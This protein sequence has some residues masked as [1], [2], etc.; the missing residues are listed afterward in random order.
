MGPDE[1][2]RKAGRLERRDEMTPGRFG[3]ARRR[4]RPSADNPVQQLSAPARSGSWRP[5]EGQLAGLQGD[6]SRKTAGGPVRVI[7]IETSSGVQV[8]RGNTQVS[9]YRV[10]LPRVS[11]ES[12]GSLAETL[13]SPD[14]PWAGDLF[15]HDAR[16]SLACGAGA[17]SSPGGIVEGPQ[18]DTL[19][20]VRNSS[21]IQLGNYNLQHNEFRVKACDVAVRADRAGLTSGRQHLVS[22]LLENPGDGAAAR[23]LAKDIGRAA[24][25]ELTADLTAQVRQAAGNPQIPLWSGDFHGLTGGQIGGPG[26]YARVEVHVTAIAKFDTQALQH[27]LQSAARRMHSTRHQPPR[28]DVR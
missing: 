8:G 27:R 3:R 17:G 25:T 9:A 26:N 24:R 16:L 19:V 21:G 12:A 4:Q 15:S 18:G 22:R 10:T 11:L 7:S 1:A 20:V 28:G 13:L 6:P 14:A 5:A 23:E 2:A